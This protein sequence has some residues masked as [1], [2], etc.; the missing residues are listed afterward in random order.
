MS[1]PVVSP[2]TSI[3]DLV[4]W[5]PEA[6]GYLR[7]KGIRCI[8]CGEPIW[9]TLEEAAKQKGFSEEQIARFVADLNALR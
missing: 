8:R 5:I 2:S 3:E 9:G 1:D 4:Q 7:D 6:V